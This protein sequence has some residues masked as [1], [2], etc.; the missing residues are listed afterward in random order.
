MAD[1]G[2]ADTEP[3][4]GYDILK[5]PHY[6]IAAGIGAISGL[7][8]AF[9]ETLYIGVAAVTLIVSGSLFTLAL[10]VAIAPLVE[11]STKPLGLLLLKEDQRMRFDLPS[12][13]LLGSLAGIGFGFAENVV[14]F[15]A[16]LPYGLTV[17]FSL[18]F[19]R[20]LLTV[21]LHA[22]TTTI[23][24]FGIGLWQ[25]SQNA[26]LLLVCLVIAMIIHGSMNL[27]ASLV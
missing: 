3:V 9:G 5:R 20:S 19:M 2:P 17:S 10:T 15:F 21:P 24:G 25:K 11:E 13:A 7:I 6:L 12:W 4:D 16:A 1:R 18:L 8:A 22:M 27:L 26:R 23:T 14:Y